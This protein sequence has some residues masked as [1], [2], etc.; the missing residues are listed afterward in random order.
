MKQ[1]Y[2]AHF[3]DLR[4]NGKAIPFA[5]YLP[6]LGLV[7]ERYL[8]VNLNMVEFKFS[9]NEQWEAY[10]QSLL[11]EM[12]SDSK[13]LHLEQYISEKE[14]MDAAAPKPLASSEPGTQKK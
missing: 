6:K 4:K 5:E 14:K 13:G 10:A 2:G 9:N 7:I 12:T 8:T 3:R 11:T 1:Q